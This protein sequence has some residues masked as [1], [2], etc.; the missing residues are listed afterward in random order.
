MQKCAVINSKSS[1]KTQKLTLAKLLKK[2]LTKDPMENQYNFSK[3]K[4]T[5]K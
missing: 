4:Q 2:G 5:V 3:Y 1:F